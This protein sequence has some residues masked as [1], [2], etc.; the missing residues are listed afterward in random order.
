MFRILA[1]A[2]IVAFF[3]QSVKA[4][5]DSNEMLQSVL[6]EE[7]GTLVYQAAGNKKNAV[8]SPEDFQ[9]MGLP[10]PVSLTEMRNTIQDFL[11]CSLKINNS[12][13]VSQFKEV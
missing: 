9:A 8:L 12:S 3:S 13:I 4:I 5:S 1:Q 6:L 10:E 2:L 11:S 7:F